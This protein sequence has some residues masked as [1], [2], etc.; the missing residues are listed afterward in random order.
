MNAQAERR[1]EQR[2]AC[3]GNMNW[4]YFNKECYGAARVFNFSQNGSHFE[5]GKALTLGS[6][7]LIHVFKCM[8]C[9]DVPKTST[10]LRWDA[11]AEVKWCQKVSD[12]GKPRYD[13]GVK[14]HDSV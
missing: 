11:L 7:V 2:H 5:T 10:K 14:Y 3:K 1:I 13:I 6:T 4:V 9:V 12:R 8:D